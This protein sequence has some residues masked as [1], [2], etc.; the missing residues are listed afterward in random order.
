MTN[1]KTERSNSCTS[2][3]NRAAPEVRSCE[4]LVVY[5]PIKQT[6]ERIVHAC[7]A[8]A[9]EPRALCMLGTL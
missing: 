6:V 5:N 1:P 4:V 9:A 2:E 3:L 8:S 7:R